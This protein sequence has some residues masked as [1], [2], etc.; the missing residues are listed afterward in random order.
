M[1][2]P[3]AN[4]KKIIATQH[5]FCISVK[6]K[7]FFIGIIN[8]GYVFNS[9]PCINM[10]EKAFKCMYIGYFVLRPFVVILSK[11]DDESFDSLDI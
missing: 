4:P 7:Y 10:A 2:E 6:L 8:I 11:S 5:E 9:N 3:R 1:L